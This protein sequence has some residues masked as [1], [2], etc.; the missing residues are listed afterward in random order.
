MAIVPH[1][2]TGHTCRC[3]SSAPLVVD[4]TEPPSVET[5]VRGPD[6]KI[7]APALVLPGGVRICTDTFGADADAVEWWK[8]LAVAALYA[9]LCYH[10]EESL[11]YSHQAERAEELSPCQPGSGLDR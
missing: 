10:G 5:I 9:S 1:G 8:D 4:P 7:S 11:S 6:G 2:R 3:V